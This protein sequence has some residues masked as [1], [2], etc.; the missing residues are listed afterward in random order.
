MAFCCLAS[1]SAISIKWEK[2]LEL[3]PDYGLCGGDVVY[4][5]DYVD[6]LVEHA[7]AFNLNDNYEVELAEYMVDILDS[8]N[9]LQGI[10]DGLLLSRHYLHHRYSNYHIDSPIL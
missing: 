1:S 5:T 7:Q 10:V 8:I 3:S 2:G 6:K 4:L 9:L